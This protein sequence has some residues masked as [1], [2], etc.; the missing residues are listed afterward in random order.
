MPKLCIFITS[1]GFSKHSLN[2]IYRRSLNYPPKGKNTDI[3]LRNNLLILITTVSGLNIGG[4]ISVPL[5]KADTD[6]IEDS[7]AFLF[8]LTKNKKFNIKKAEVS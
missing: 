1:A 3:R 6:Y 7:G 2:L 4:F 5:P 8:T